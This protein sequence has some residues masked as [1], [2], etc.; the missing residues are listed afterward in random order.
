MPSRTYVEPDPDAL[1]VVP[2]PAVPDVVDPDVPLVVPPV[3]PYDPLLEPTV[4]LV[5][6]YCPPRLV[7]PDV[8][9]P[10]VPLVP[11]V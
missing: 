8:A 7:D 2:D 4:A 1:P 6:M 11:L 3:E 9:V 10:L 5:R